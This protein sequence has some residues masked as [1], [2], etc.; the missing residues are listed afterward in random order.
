MAKTVHLIRHG[1][2]TANVAL[3]INPGVD[4]GVRDAP[5][6]EL[7]H[8][9]VKQLRSAVESLTIDLVVTSPLTRTI[10]TTLGA[11]GG[12]PVPVVVEPLHREVLAYSSSQGRSPV[13][14]AGEF[15]ALEFEHLEDP[16]WHHDPADPKAVLLETEEILM[17]RVNEFHRWLQARAEPTIAVVGH[18][19]SSTVSAAIISETAKS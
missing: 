12:R 15:P 9:Q 6:T 7:G 3:E 16:W 17:Q 14:L 4:P 8:H 1:Q 13:E 2:S 10:Q 18:T 11:F 5:L 19:C